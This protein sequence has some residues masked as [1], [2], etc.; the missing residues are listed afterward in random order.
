[1]RTR[2]TTEQK[3]NIGIAKAGNNNKLQ[4]HTTTTITQQ[5]QHQ[6]PILSVRGDK[7]QNRNRNK[8][9]K[10]RTENYGQSVAWTMTQRKQHDS[11]QRNATRANQRKITITSHKNYR[12]HQHTNNISQKC[13]TSN[14]IRKQRNK[15]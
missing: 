1:M 4:Q 13:S 15:S 12:T 5:R 7:C 9:F 14:N 3:F 8:Q 10:G 11:T 6:M 2:T